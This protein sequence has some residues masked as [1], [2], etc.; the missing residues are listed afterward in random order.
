MPGGHGGGGLAGMLLRSAAG[1]GGPGRGMGGMKMNSMNGESQGTQSSSDVYDVDRWKRAD[2]LDS[3]FEPTLVQ[4]VRDAWERETKEK[5]KNSPLAKIRTFFQRKAGMESQRKKKRREERM[6]RRAQGSAARRDDYEKERGYEEAERAR[7]SGRDSRENGEHQNRSLERISSERQRGMKEGNT[8]ITP[9]MRKSLHHVPEIS[10]EEES[11]SRSETDSLVQ[12]KESRNL[13]GLRTGA[14]IDS[15]FG[16][17]PLNSI[18]LAV[19]SLSFGP[20]TVNQVRQQEVSF[21]ADSG[22]FPREKTADSYAGPSSEGES[23]SDKIRP[24]GG[25]NMKINLITNRTGTHYMNSLREEREQRKYDVRVR[26][27]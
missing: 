7:E 8:I 11:P 17:S 12:F 23:V 10:E 13:I 15:F 20:L 21:N 19:D 6:E 18:L 26:N 3:G 27:H 16:N 5:K 4:T 9:G 22:L 2:D 25:S 24:P 1:G 14:G